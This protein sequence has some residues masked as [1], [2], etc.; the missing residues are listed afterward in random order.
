MRVKM[1]LQIIDPPHTFNCSSK[2]ND[3]ILFLP[4]ALFLLSLHLETK[5]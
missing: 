2:I 4:I 1:Q 3:D 5:S